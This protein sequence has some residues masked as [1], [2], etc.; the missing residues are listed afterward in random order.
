MKRLAL[1]LPLLAL[2]A[3]PARAEDPAAKEAMESARL[4]EVEARILSLS[5]E[6]TEEEKRAVIS[7]VDALSENERVELTRRLPIVYGGQFVLNHLAHDRQKSVRLGV[8]LNR[9]TPKES[10]QFLCDDSEED[11]RLSATNNLESVRVL[12]LN[13]LHGRIEPFILD[14]VDDNPYIKSR[15]IQKQKDTFFSLDCLSHRS[16]RTYEDALAVLSGILEKW[17]DHPYAAYVEYTNLLRQV[18]AFQDEP[19]RSA[20]AESFHAASILRTLTLPV[21]TNLFPVVESKVHSLRWEMRERAWREGA[22]AISIQTVLEIA[23]LRARFAKQSESIRKLVAV[24][25][26]QEP[27]MGETREEWRNRQQWEDRDRFLKRRLNWSLEDTEIVHTRLFSE[28]PSNL[29]LEKMK[30]WTTERQRKTLLELLNRADLDEDAFTA[31]RNA[32]NR[33]FAE[34]RE[35]ESERSPELEDIP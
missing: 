30:G 31:L 12:R 10:L 17:H 25:S 28:Y 29:L 23:E 19:P 2:A 24:W 26:N 8:S 18:S 13:D 5:T 21:P 6:P 22:E 27:A 1:L 16:C 9:W 11:I 33:T 14:F 3:A 20:A 32:V 4:S 34:G 35:E 7:A 15:L